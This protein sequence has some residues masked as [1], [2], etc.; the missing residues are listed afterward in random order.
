LTHCGLPPQGNRIERETRRLNVDW[1]DGRCILCRAKGH[2]TPEGRLTAEHIIP[3]AVGG[4]L[5]C[6][7]L[8]KVCNEV[9]G[10][11]EAKLKKDP[12]VRL[13]I[14]NLNDQTPWLHKRMSPNQGFVAE[15]QGGTVEG[16]YRK[17]QSSG[18]LEF[19]VNTS[20]KPDGSLVAPTDDARKRLSD[21][22]RQDGFSEAG[23]EEALRKF[24]EAPEDIRVTVAPGFDIVKWA[25]TRVGP[26]LD[27]R[28]SLVRLA[29]GGEEVLQGAGISLLKVAFEYLAL[30]VGSEILSPV[31]DP[32][33]DA[34]R[35]ND[36]SLSPHRVEWKRGPRLEA[37]HR[38][39]I[40]PAPSYI[41]VQ[42]RLFGEL[43]YR[44]HFPNVRAGKKFPRFAY[45]H[46]LLQR[47]ERFQEV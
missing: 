12:A 41:V 18:G 42:I 25:V 17:D 29:P 39:V 15:S 20:Q 31:L 1:P 47:R 8:C 9:L 4:V 45:T 2:R 32:V 19:R 3:R 16:F 37:F 38:L 30:H 22:L 21:M 28:L 14:Q 7:F 23:I 26:K 33:R 36:A 13:A 34:L 10:G 46:D 27:G 40:E 6:N 35:R 44:V 11:H 5:T 24:D 43:A